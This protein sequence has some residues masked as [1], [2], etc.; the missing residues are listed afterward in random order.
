MIVPIY[1]K[2]SVGQ[3]CDLNHDNMVVLSGMPPACAIFPSTITPGV[4]II[5]YS[6]ILTWSSIF[7]GHFCENDK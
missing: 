3:H 6:I 1:A 2:V 4:D 5:P 7:S